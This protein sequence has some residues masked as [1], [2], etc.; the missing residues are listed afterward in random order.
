MSIKFVDGVTPL[1]A[2]NL[3]Q[4]VD[5]AKSAGSNTQNLAEQVGA[6]TTTIGQLNTNT[7][8]LGIQVGAN[9]AAIGRLNSD[10]GILSHR[11]DELEGF[12][13]LGRYESFVPSISMW[14]GWGIGMVELNVRGTSAPI[15]GVLITGTYVATNSTGSRTIYRHPFVVSIRS[16]ADSTDGVDWSS[17]NNSAPGVRHYLANCS[18]CCEDYNQFKG[19][20]FVS[21]GG[22]ITARIKTTLSAP[23]SVLSDMSHRAPRLENVTIRALRGGM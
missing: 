16:A 4:V 14:G 22:S 2:H 11:V 9:T 13:S 5:L 21:S 10:I 20:C 12:G 8:N 19:V 23:W 18:W 17:I 15:G 1:N 6:N 7:Q 3:N